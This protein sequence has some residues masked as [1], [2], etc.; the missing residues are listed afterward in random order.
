MTRPST[1]RASFAL[2]MIPRVQTTL[3][4][5]LAPDDPKHRA[6]LAVYLGDSKIS[7]VLLALDDAP[8]CDRCDQVIAFAI[9]VDVDEDGARHIGDCPE[10]EP[11]PEPDGEAG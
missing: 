7:T 11:E 10:P 9:E 4:P 1:R 8:T 5:I 3:T 6:E 2:L